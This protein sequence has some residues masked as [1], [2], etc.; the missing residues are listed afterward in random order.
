[1]SVLIILDILAVAIGVG[2]A[3]TRGV[4]AMA[5]PAA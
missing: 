2:V 4:L 1:M 5:R 3:C